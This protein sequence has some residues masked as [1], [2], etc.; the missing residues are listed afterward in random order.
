MHPFLICP[1]WAFNKPVCR[2]GLA[3]RGD[4]ALAPDDVLHALSSGINFWNWPGES[5]GSSIGD[6]FSHAIAGLGGQRES[7][8]VCVQFAARTAKEAAGEL[9]SVLATLKTDYIDI[10]TLYYVEELAEWESLIAAGGAL[11]YCREARADGVIRRLGMTTH[12]RRLAKT[13]VRSGLLDVLMIRYNAAHRGAAK[14]IFPVTDSLRMPVIAY[15]ALRWGALLKPTPNDP[16]GFA[17]PSAPSWYRF[18]LQSESIAVTLAAPQ[19]RH[20]LAEA[21]EVLQATEPLTPAE[22]EQ[23]A[24][25]GDR[26]RRYAGAFP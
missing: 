1:R 16:P 14:D 3:S 6:A 9:R 11:E 12:Q 21:L 2:L 20:E 5:E 26:V 10:L 15:T 17:V 18:V 23:L 25:H 8:V 22:Y 13:C 4:S 7:V 24:S 19:N